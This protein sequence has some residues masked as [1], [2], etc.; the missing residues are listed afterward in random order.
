ME[1]V[2]LFG[3]PVKDQPA[4][5][6]S[7]GDRVGPNGVGYIDDVQ[8]N[9]VIIAYEGDPVAPPRRLPVYLRNEPELIG[10]DTAFVEV[11]N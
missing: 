8:P 11:T 5:I 1:P 10:F 7:I 3:L 6:A 4:Q 9:R 2:A